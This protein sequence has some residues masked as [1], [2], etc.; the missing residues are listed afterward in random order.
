ML[1]ILESGP[2]FSDLV[3]GLES[4]KAEKEA[5]MKKKFADVINEEGSLDEIKNFIDLTVLIGDGEE[6][7]KHVPTLRVPLNWSNENYFG[8][9]FI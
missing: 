7:V 1:N 8:E 9:L 5:F 3:L 4:K 6:I 2:I